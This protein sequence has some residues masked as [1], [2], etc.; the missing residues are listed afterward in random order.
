[1]SIRIESVHNT[2]PYTHHV[3]T[4]RIRIYMLLPSL[5]LDTRVLMLHAQGCLYANASAALSD[6]IVPPACTGAPKQTISG[7]EKNGQ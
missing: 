6:I 1:M 3:C 2:L 5:L 4:T 7:P